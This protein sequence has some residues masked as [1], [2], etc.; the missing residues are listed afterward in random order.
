MLAPLLFAL[1]K[2]LRRA[3]SGQVD[4]HPARAAHLPARRGLH[5]ALPE[6]GRRRVVSGPSSSFVLSSSRPVCCPVCVFIP[7]VVAWAVRTSSP[8]VCHVHAF[9]ACVSRMSVHACPRPC[10]V[11]H[12][13]ALR[14]RSLGV[15]VC[16]R[17]P[18]ASHLAPSRS[19]CFLPSSARRGR[20]SRSLF[21]KV[22]TQRTVRSL[23]ADFRHRVLPVHCR[24]HAR[25]RPRA[26]PC[27]SHSRFLPRWRAPRSRCF[28]GWRGWPPAALPE[29]SSSPASTVA[30]CAFCPS[31]PFLFSSLSHAA[32][33]A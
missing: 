16:A 17:F 14:V 30:F 31:L 12:G 27:Q 5:A 15:P 13:F 10:V 33:L 25:R 9:A 2:R 8:C 24:F 3:R 21:P 20:F 4:E 26:P 29:S 19:A 11:A 32:K 28:C 18:C 6:G 1:L 22:S 23:A 7:A